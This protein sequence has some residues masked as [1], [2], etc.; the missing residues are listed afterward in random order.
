MVMIETGR[1][2][3]G[4]DEGSVEMGVLGWG[5]VDRCGVKP[6]GVGGVGGG[7]A[8]R[9]GV[10]TCGGRGVTLWCICVFVCLCVCV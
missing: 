9:T 5:N 6:G 3:V 7:G 4:T 1:G 8:A 10:V 2:V